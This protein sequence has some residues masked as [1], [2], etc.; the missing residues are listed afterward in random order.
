MPREVFDDRFV[1][2]PRQDMLSFEEIERLARIFVGL[3]VRKLRLSGGEPLMRKD[4]QDLV[5]KLAQLHTPDEAMPEIALTT[6]ASLLSRK[7]AVLARAGLARVNVSLDAIDSAVFQRMT[8]SAVLV[9]DVLNGIDAAQKAGLG[10]IKVNM[11]V[12]RGMNED[13]ILPMVRHFRGSGHVLRFIE[14]MDVGNSNKW[15]QNDVFTAA[16]ILSTIQ[17]EHPLVAIQAHNRSDVARRWKYADGQG[18]IGII[19]SVTQPFCG[20]CTR[21]RLS[22]DGKLYLCLFAQRGID[23]RAPLRSGAT[24]VE[25]EKIIR[26]AWSART[27]RYSEQRGLSNGRPKIEMSYIGG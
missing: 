10:P 8:D 3:G 1:F 19:A 11:V 16:E 2:L 25:L 9:D 21:A 22:A 4:L 24:N 26:A 13:Q 27:D 7:A 12:R 23:L 5:A 20:D 18:E 14:F 15:Q 6:N 17:S